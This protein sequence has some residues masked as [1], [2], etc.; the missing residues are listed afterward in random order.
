MISFLF[1][2]YHYF[3]NWVMQNH[4]LTSVST[5]PKFFVAQFF[6]A[7]KELRLYAKYS[8]KF[9]CAQFFYCTEPFSIAKLLC[10]ERSSETLTSTARILYT[11]Q[12]PLSCATTVS[13]LYVHCMLTVLVR[14]LYTLLHANRELVNY[15]RDK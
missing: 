7:K 14:S 9:F 3:K 4:H 12:E 10:V 13:L 11:K 6:T 5:S 1:C 2:F 8:T 15:P